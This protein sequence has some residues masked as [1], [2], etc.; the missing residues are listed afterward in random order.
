MD[1]KRLAMGEVTCPSGTLLVLDMGLLSG[2]SHDEPHE[3]NPDM[4]MTGQPFVDLEIVGPDAARAAALLGDEADGD[5]DDEDDGDERIPLYDIP[6]AGFDRLAKRFAAKAKEA[7]LDARLEK[8]KARVP[9]G[10]RVKRGLAMGLRS[11]NV[12]FHVGNAIFLRDVP[13]D[14]KLHVVGVRCH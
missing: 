8:T 14:K 5:E 11:G 10:E 6:A 2:W 1:S 3:T 7:K 4:G 12:P 9:H 13:R